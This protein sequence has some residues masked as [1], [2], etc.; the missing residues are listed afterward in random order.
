MKTSTKRKR[1]STLDGDD[2]CQ[3][4][5][6]ILTS[7]HHL[8]E[9]VRYRDGA[10]AAGGKREPPLPLVR[11]RAPREQRAHILARKNFFDVG[12]V[13]ALASGSRGRRQSDRV[14]G[15]LHYR[16]THTVWEGAPSGSPIAS[17]HDSKRTDL[18]TQARSMAR[19]HGSPMPHMSSP[20]RWMPPALPKF[21]I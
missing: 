9:A 4:E 3:P 17:T 2:V 19:T 16:G 14:A 21:W 12:E 6:L 11:A 10:S 8:M 1:K 7:Q 13:V 5:R 20:R 15:P 18:G